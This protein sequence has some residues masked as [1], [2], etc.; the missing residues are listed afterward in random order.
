[1]K[2]ADSGAK[3]DARRSTNTGDAVTKKDKKF[4]QK[5]WLTL[6]NVLL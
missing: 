2:R 1:M 3:Q 5:D 4:E 6:C